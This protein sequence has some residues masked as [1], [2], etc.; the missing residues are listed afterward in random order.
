MHTVDLLDRALAAAQQLG[1]KV[2]QEWIG[3]F[4]GGGCQIKNQKW[5][6]VD[7]ALS[8]ADQLRQVAEAL[9]GDPGLPELQLASELRH[10]VQRKAA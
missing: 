9:R 8:P 3:G 1:F 5:I 4:G 2:R 6:F 7:I 10:V